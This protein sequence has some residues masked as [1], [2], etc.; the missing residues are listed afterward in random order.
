[1]WAIRGGVLQPVN[2]VPLPD[3]KYAAEPSIRNVSWGGGRGLIK[4]S[5]G[6]RTVSCTYENGVL[7]CQA[8]PGR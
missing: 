7:R 5:Y 4:L 3:A 1:M 8:S 2:K 6:K